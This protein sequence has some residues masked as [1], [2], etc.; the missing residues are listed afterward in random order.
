ME[1]LSKTLDRR[2]ARGAV[3]ERLRAATAPRA[4]DGELSAE[5][6]RADKAGAPMARSGARTVTRVRSRRPRRVHDLRRRRAREHAPADAAHVRGARADRAAALAQGH[7]PVLA[8][9]RREAAPHPGDDGRARPEPGGRR[10]RAAPGGGDRRAC[11]RASRRSSWRRCRR[12]CAWPR[13]SRRCA[14]RSAPSS[15]VPY[16]GG[17]ELVRAADAPFSPF[18]QTRSQQTRT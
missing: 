13:S 2:P 11:T 9:G 18:Q 6:Q 16:R 14:A 3:R 12:R 17:L 4:A 10:A 7:A 1:Q 8:G 5:G 15:T